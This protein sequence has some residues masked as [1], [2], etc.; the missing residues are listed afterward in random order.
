MNPAHWLIHTV[1]RQRQLGLDTA[2]DPIL[3]PVTSIKAL[4]EHKHKSIRNGEGA[5]VQISATLFT[6]EEPRTSD[7]Y[8]LPGPDLLT[9]PP[10]TEGNRGRSPA[11]IEGATALGPSRG[12]R[13]WLVH[14]GT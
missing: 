8:W 3:G 6:L 7:T 2:G 5:E 10:S 9:A 14:F 1:R 11:A 12:L 13:A 4:V